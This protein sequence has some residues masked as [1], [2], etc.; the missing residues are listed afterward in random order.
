MN[1]RLKTHS[2]PGDVNKRQKEAMLE[3]RDDRP[4]HASKEGAK[5]WKRTVRMKE[6]AVLKERARVRIAEDS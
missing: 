3:G 6:R 2:Y 4:S 5:R 1:L